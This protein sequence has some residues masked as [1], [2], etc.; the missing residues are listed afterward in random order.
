ML[1]EVKSLSPFVFLK[2]TESVSR[3]VTAQMDLFSVDDPMALP[4]RTPNGI[5]TPKAEV[6]KLFNDVEAAAVL[7][8]ESFNI[9]PAFVQFPINVRI[10]SEDT[11]EE[12]KRPYATCKTHTDIWVGEPVNNKTVIIPLLGRGVAGCLEFGEPK[13]GTFDPV[14]YEREYPSYEEGHKAISHVQWYDVVP[15]AGNAYILDARCLHKSKWGGLR[16][17][18]DFRFCM[19]EPAPSKTR[20]A[21]INAVDWYQKRTAFAETAADTIRRYT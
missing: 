9:D 14:L 20:D 1:V 8:L 13:P 17:S 2:L 16:I 3:Y 11:D 4:S 21:Y 6:L 12:R 19:E 10:K 5:I 15:S 7:A 18:L